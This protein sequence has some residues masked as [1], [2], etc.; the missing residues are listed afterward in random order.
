MHVLDRPPIPVTSGRK[1]T[2]SSFVPFGLMC[3]VV[4]SMLAYSPVFFN[5]FL[6]D[7]F[8]HLTW[9]TQ[10]V[11]NWELIWRNFHSSWLDGTTTRFY[12]PLI[13]VFMVSDYLMY[14]LNGLGFRITNLLF[15]LTSSLLIFMI[16][17]RAARP[18]SAR[19]SNNPTVDAWAL[20]SAAIFALYPLHPEPVSWITGRVDTVVTT[21][22]LGSFWCYLRWRS[23]FNNAWLVAASL[24]FVLGLLSKEMAITMPAVLVVYEGARWLQVRLEKHEPTEYPLDDADTNQT[25]KSVLF[26]LATFWVILAAYFVVRLIS[27]KTVVGGYDDSLLFIADPQGFLLNWVYGL[28]MMVVPLNKMLMGWHHWLTN[29]WLVCLASSAALAV[30]TI[31][32]DRATRVFIGFVSIW[33]VMCLLPVY[34][35]FSITAD[36]QGSRLAYLATVPLSILLA[37]GF[38]RSLTVFTNKNV[39]SAVVGLAAL[40]IFANTAA[41]WMN[42]Q[43]W[44]QAGLEAN[45]IRSALS[46]LY[47]LVPG[48][49]QV[50]LI[51]LPDQIN[52]AYTCRNALWGMTKAP[53]LE[54]DIVNCQMV[55]QFEPIFPFGYL[56]QSLW[57]NK[58]NV[59]IRR[60]SPTEKQLIPVALP[61]LNDRETISWS[62]DQLKTMVVAGPG[63]RLHWNGSMA[64]VTAHAQKLRPGADIEL[65]GVDCFN[66][67]FVRVKANLDQPGNTASGADLLYQN[68]ANPEFALDRR[69]HSPATNGSSQEWLFAMRSLPEWSLGGGKPRLRLLLP[70]GSI[71]S[72]TAIEVVNRKQVMPTLSFEN[73][74]YLGSK[75]YLHLSNSEPVKELQV[76]ASNLPSAVATEIET[77][78]T[79][80]LFEEQHST[81]LS[82]LR[83]GLVKGPLTGT[84]KLHKDDFPN[85]GIYELRVWAKDAADKTVGVCSDHIVISVDPDER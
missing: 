74:G 34:K 56:K 5:F 20:M 26:G 27:L 18:V 3:I 82:K 52:G 11:N 32:K 83:R 84:I 69:T 46:K 25:L 77:T 6:G 50:L 41:L 55:N 78:R 71:T 28:R 58:A 47:S 63:S 79:N 24:S 48:D 29:V 67:E 76:D 59:L 17:R 8:V 39:R 43:P 9:L 21:F 38:T 57:E 7:D 31:V 33:L 13:S 53:Q 36:L 70:Q 72:I 85:A 60:W 19:P 42:N 37:Y 14:G 22:I 80:L 23:S 68:N 61:A 30:A 65:P 12:R 51:G 64:T 45:A 1:R 35:I 10:A 75:G 4:L 2:K 81:T 40:F 66:V 44:R 54:R 49:P 15:H 16:V 73:S 62:G